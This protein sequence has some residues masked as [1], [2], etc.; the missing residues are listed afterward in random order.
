MTIN[1]KPRVFI[2]GCGGMLGQAVYR[3][4]SEHYEVLATDIDLNEPWLDYADVIDLGS[5]EKLAIDFRP[6]LIIN[7]AA[8]TDLEYCE[9]NPQEAWKTNALG[10]ENMALVSQRLDIPH[11]YISTAGIFDGKQE[12][13][14]DFD[15]PNPLGIYA[16]SKY[17]GETAVQRMLDKYYV[18]RAGWMMGGGPKKDKKF[19]NKIFKQIIAGEKI[20]RVVDDKLGT[21]TYTGNFAE[22]MLRIV[23]TD[24]YGLYNMAC[25]GSCSRYDV[26]VEFVRLLGME[27]KVKIK[28][29]DSDYFNSEYFAPRPASE[30][31]VNLKL[32]SRGINFMRDWRECL[33]EYAEEFNAVMKPNRGKLILKE[34]A[35]AV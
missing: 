24:L 7:L 22:S 21:P 11:V 8:L 18:F 12:Y 34:E 1:N 5:V 3:R 9:Q 33:A 15:R 23:Q 10:A 32:D 28:I 20:L 29:V 35:A 13:Y 26:A 27:D 4:F 6:D 2:T 30:K 31:L 25:S 17:Y 16:R 19:I 14:N